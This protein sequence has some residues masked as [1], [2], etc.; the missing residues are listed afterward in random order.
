MRCSSL[1][2]MPSSGPL[3]FR[4]VVGVMRGVGEGVTVG[5][6]VGVTVPV[7]V[8]V[9]VPVGVGVIV[10]VGVGV[11]GG[12]SVGVGVIDDVPDEAMITLMLPLLKQM[13]ELDF[14]LPS[15]P[16]QWTAKV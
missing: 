8:G 7:G 14:L 5:V 12:V 4:Y 11:G 16:L 2:F 3:L 13:T 10:P 15:Q 6:G 9:I 1:F